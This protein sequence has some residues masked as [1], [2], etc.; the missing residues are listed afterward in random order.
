[1][2][3]REAALRK[4]IARLK[5]NLKAQDKAWRVADKEAEKL[6]KVSW[7]A[8]RKALRLED[9]A[10]DTELALCRAQEELEE[11]TEKP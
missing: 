8:E 3:K 10:G 4:R 2:T 5:A 6:A 9:K 11:L 7:R 1:M